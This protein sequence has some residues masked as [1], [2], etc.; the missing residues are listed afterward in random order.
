[1][2]EA[3]FDEV[4]S[5]PPSTIDACELIDSPHKRIAPELA[6]RT[7]RLQA[8]GACSAHVEALSLLSIAGRG[9]GRVTCSM[10]DK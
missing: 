7:R 3:A 5:T 6:D 2:P 9:R 10:R 8:T 1:M 4:L